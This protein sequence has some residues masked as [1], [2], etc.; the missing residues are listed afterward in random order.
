MDEEI[1]L[2]RL[3][4]TRIKGYSCSDP[5]LVP[6]TK[7]LSV[8]IANAEGDAGLGALTIAAVSQRLEP[9]REIEVRDILNTYALRIASQMGSG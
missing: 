1:V 9:E 3:Q 2:E 7:A 5:G 8:S 6:G 4:E